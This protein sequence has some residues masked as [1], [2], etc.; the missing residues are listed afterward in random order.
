M[1]SKHNDDE[2]MKKLHQP[3]RIILVDFLN[4]SSSSFDEMLEVPE[5][6]Q[7]SLELLLKKKFLKQQFG[8][9]K[10]LLNREL[11]YSNFFPVEFM[12]DPE[13]VLNHIQ[14]YGYGL[15]YASSQLKQDREFVLQ[16]VQLKGE[17]LLFAE[18]Y[19]KNDPEV[20]LTAIKQDAQALY[21]ASRELQYDKRFVLEAVRLN[22]KALCAC[23]TF[24]KDM[25]IVFTAL[26]QNGEAL[27]WFEFSR[28]SK[29]DKL[30]TL[31]AIQ[32]TKNALRWTPQYLLQDD[33]F[34]LQA[35]KI[36]SPD[37]FHSFDYS[38]NEI[39]S[40]VIQHFGFLLQFA[41]NELMNDRDI[42]LKA[43]RNDGCSLQ[44]ASDRL[45]ND[46]EIALVAVT[47]NGWALKYVSLEL[48]RDKQV[49]VAAISQNGYAL[50]FASIELKNDKDVVLLAISQHGSLL[51]YVSYD[52]KEVVLAAVKQYS[53]ALEYASYELKND[54][55]IVSEAIK[56]GYH[57]LQFASDELLCDKQFLLQVAKYGG[58]AFLN[59]VPE[60]VTKDNEFMLKVREEIKSSGFASQF[61]EEFYL[62]RIEQCYYGA[63]FGLNTNHRVCSN[64]SSPPA[65][66]FM[67]TPI[68]DER[69]SNVDMGKTLSFPEFHCDLI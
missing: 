9:K 42:V 58:Q 11:K 41:S 38:N 3:L 32:Q 52:D 43:V 6:I 48:K 34:M 44:F 2:E 66:V 19:F 12:N 29:K 20:L 33:A 16:V 46:K 35:L 1:S 7:S 63:Y 24:Q 15:I 45:K 50:A 47:Q 23:F 68:S 17:E 31:E 14:K 65:Y 37:N 26:K 59:Y 30:M 40:K 64:Q 61:N 57:S 55:E 56:E 21:R 25:D 62:E 10:W 54:Q 67:E 22:G 4:S 13:F 53:G 51:Q 18:K 39:M 5:I 28:D 36:I 49:V 8:K 27:Q 60:E 69:S